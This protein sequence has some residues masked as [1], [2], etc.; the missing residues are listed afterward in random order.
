MTSGELADRDRHRPLHAERRERGQPVDRGAGIAARCT[1]PRRGTPP[2]RRA[3]APGKFVAGHAGRSH[4]RR[5][6]S[7]RPA[8]PGTG[9]PGHAGGAQPVGDGLA[10]GL[11]QAVVAADV[12]EHPAP[13][14]GGRP[15]PGRSPP[16]PGGSRP[17][18]TIARPGSRTRRGPVAAAEVTQFSEALTAWPSTSISARVPEGRARAVRDGQASADIDH[19]QRDAGRFQLLRDLRRRRDADVPGVGVALLGADVPGD[20]E[21]RRPWRRRVGAAAGAPCRG[22]SRTCRRTA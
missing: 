22:R 3:P 5:R 20:A 7:V 6:W 12:Q 2:R 9:G 17:R 10:L 14:V 16:R 11:D 19:R 4:R 8:R 13:Q 1:P 21:G 18:P 15:P